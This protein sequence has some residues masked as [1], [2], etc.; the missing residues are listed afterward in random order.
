[1]VNKLQVIDIVCWISWNC[2]NCN[3]CNFIYVCIAYRN[4]WKTYG[5][6]I[7]KSKL[8]AGTKAATGC[9]CIST[10]KRK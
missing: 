8:Y 3:Y 5:N 10:E 7:G 9:K 4:K 1:M 2:K 6:H